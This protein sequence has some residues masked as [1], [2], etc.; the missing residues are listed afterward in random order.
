METSRFPSFAHLLIPSTVC[1]VCGRA[2]G[3]SSVLEIPLSRDWG[4]FLPL[5]DTDSGFSAGRKGYERAVTE[6]ITLFN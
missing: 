6:R 4:V 5:G 3:M 2:P 1:I